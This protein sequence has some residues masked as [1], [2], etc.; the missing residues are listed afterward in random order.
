MF[1]FI[2]PLERGDLTTVD[3]GEFGNTAEDDAFA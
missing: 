2:L 1:N 3:D